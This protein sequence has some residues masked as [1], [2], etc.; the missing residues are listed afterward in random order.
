MNMYV[1][2]KKSAS[3]ALVLFMSTLIGAFSRTFEGQESSIAVDRLRRSSEKLAFDVVSIHLSS[4]G[5]ASNGIWK[6][7]PN[8][9][10]I[11]NQVVW[12]TIMLAYSPLPRE[13]WRHDQLVGVPFWTEGY[14]IDAKVDQQTAERWKGMTDSQRLE[15][16]KLMLQTMLVDRYHLVIHSKAGESPAYLLVVGKHAP[17]LNTP[18]PLSTKPLGFYK[19]PEGGGWFST[20]THDIAF[21][22]TSMSSLALF[23]SRTSPYPIEDRT[24]LSGNYDFE[25]T[26]RQ[27]V[28]SGAD[29]GTTSKF[30]VE[31]LGLKLVRSKIQVSHL[32][33]DHI[34]KP[35]SN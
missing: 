9:L 27:D 30:D 10:L 8:A 23:L 18:K 26:P 17:K 22:S 25:L 15:D 31:S 19:F 13:Y 5:N 29:P 35:S 33:V 11:R 6:L 20:P 28:S 2:S 14:D 12:S 7:S 24:G 1:F 3:L 34:E 4:A 21:S 16:A 32:V